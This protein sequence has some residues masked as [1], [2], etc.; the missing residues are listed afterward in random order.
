M[1]KLIKQAT[2]QAEALFPIGTV[3]EQTGVHSVTLRAWERRYG[4]LRP[5]RTPKG[6]RLYSQQDIHRVK[7]VLRLL[8]QGIPVSRAQEILRKHAT[9]EQTDLAEQVRLVAGEDPWKQYTSLCRRS[10]YKL[11][12]KALEKVIDEAI[13]SY[14]L[15]IVAHKLLLPLCTDLYGQCCLLTSTR[16]DHA[17]WYQ[18]LSAKLGAYYLNTHMQSRTNGFRV[19]VIGVTCQMVYLQTLMLACTLGMQG[20]QVSLLGADCRPEHLPLVLERSHFDALIY[21]NPDTTVLAGLEVLSRMTKT[22]LLVHY[23]EPD[24]QPALPETL[25]LLPLAFNEASLQLESLLLART[26]HPQDHHE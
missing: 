8:E 26:P 21:C 15:E 20:F 25:K 11:D 22:E 3:S 6:H 9:D 14:S 7:Q 17:F 4:L 16:A 19:I 24:K 18:F 12:A 10:I 13:A 2:M 5:S 1:V 23:L